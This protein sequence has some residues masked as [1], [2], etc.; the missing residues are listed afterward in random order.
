MH[1]IPTQCSIILKIYIESYN[2]FIGWKTPW[3]LEDFQ[4][5]EIY[6]YPSHLGGGFVPKIHFVTT[7]WAST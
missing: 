5:S 3:I 6:L 7:K 1:I 2:I 4:Q